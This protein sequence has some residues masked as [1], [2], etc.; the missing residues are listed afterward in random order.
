ML[1][2]VL[3]L[4]NES[5]DNGAAGGSRDEKEHDEDDQAGGTGQRGGEQQQGNQ[6]GEDRRRCAQRT[7]METTVWVLEPEE[8]DH[9]H[10]AEGGSN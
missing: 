4:P 5:G 9:T 8:T 3:T 6:V 2:G 7:C 10:N 1:L